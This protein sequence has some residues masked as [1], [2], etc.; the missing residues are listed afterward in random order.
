MSKSRLGKGLDALLS[1]TTQA[2]TPAQTTQTPVQSSSAAASGG[3]MNI[4]VSDI[5]RSP[6]QPRRHFNEAALAELATSISAQGVLQPLVVRSR[7]QGGFEL[8]AG[9]RRWRAAQQAGL[10][11]IFQTTTSLTTHLVRRT[12]LQKML[13]Q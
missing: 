4:N 3:L 13:N 12:R 10:S 8:I 11:E 1:S 5:V 7:P 6:Y 2:Q 9:E